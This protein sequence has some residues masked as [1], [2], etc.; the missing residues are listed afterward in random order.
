MSDAGLLR[1]GTLLLLAKLVAVVGG[2]ALYWL[3]AHVFSASL[4]EVAG[5]AAF[6]VWGATFGVINPL[7]SMAAAGTMQ[8][9]SRLVAS[10][11]QGPAGAVFW[12]AARTQ[13]L[14]VVAI[15]AA[16]ELAAGFVA[17]SVLNDAAY[18]TPLRLAAA[19]PLLYALR[20]LYEGYLNG[21]R[22]FR[23]QA[24]LDMGATV[25]RLV[26]VL[27]AAAA[28]HGA[29]G[30]IGGVVAAAAAMAAVAVVWVRPA[31]DP[32][33]AAGALP[34]ARR[35]LTFQAQ[36]I[37]VTLATQ[38]L[39]HVDLLAV[40]AL[41]SPDPAVAD[42]LAGY[43]T[44]A[45]KL[46][47]VPL[48]IVLALATLMFSYVASDHARARAVV[49]QGMRALLLLMVPAAALLA[50]NA[51]ETLWLVFPT[52]ER[53]L[54]AAGDAPAAASGALAWLAVGYVPCA[55]FLTSTTLVTADGRPG[56][57]AAIAGA[58]LVV[59]WFAVRAL[60]PLWGAPGAAIGVSGAF[61]LGLVLC[62]AV[63]ARRF[64]PPVGALTALRVGAGGVAVAALAR[65]IPSDGAW[66]L[67]E[68]AALV[69]VFLLL[70]LGSRE[71]RVAELRDALRTIGRA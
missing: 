63:L 22:R 43:Y 55:L 11:A 61:V 16:L 34:G 67:L 6:G 49:R 50:A 69:G 9:M 37:A 15:F 28:G 31:R 39:I 26:F 30:A 23:D 53:S 29:F 47:Q 58:T 64:G 65:A 56:L 1:G 51:G 70:M 3:L 36:V 25:L 20:A 10:R 13:L 54:L 8:M 40:K 46:A 7:N 45:Q 71:L 4:G 32:D 66:L 21:T 2:F 12:H 62:G 19:I 42:R 18:A 57:S 14:L 60:T 68:D 44:A 52:L 48:S 59:A 38:Y 33:G 35:V 17:R 41:A 5:A 24:L 27:A